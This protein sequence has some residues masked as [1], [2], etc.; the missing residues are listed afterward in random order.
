MQAGHVSLSDGSGRAAEWF[1]PAPWHQ[2]TGCRPKHHY[3]RESLSITGDTR[4]NRERWM[5]I[6]FLQVSTVLPGLP[7]FQQGR[8][9][10]LCFAPGRVTGVASGRQCT[11][12]IL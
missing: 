7:C 1:Q 10:G 2:D 6:Y 5:G 9:P 12:A 3:H 8:N 4:P 11:V